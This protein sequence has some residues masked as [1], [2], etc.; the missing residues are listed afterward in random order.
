MIHILLS[1]IL[2]I[3]NLH[4]N[5]KFILELLRSLLNFIALGESKARHSNYLRETREYLP[6]SNAWNSVTLACLLGFVNSSSQSGGRL[7]ML[8][9][10]SRRLTKSDLNSF[11]LSLQAAIGIFESV[12]AE[13]AWA[14]CLDGCRDCILFSRNVAF[15]NRGEYEKEYKRF[16]LLLNYKRLNLLHL[17]YLYL[18]SHILLAIWTKIIQTVTLILI[19]IQNF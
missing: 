6:L 14:K 12:V 15:N 17:L 19:K 18:V 8:L 1:Q 4:F 5:I 9:Q 13:R 16:I 3:Y 10:L 7:I 11:P 2:L